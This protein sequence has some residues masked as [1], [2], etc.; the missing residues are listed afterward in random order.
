[1]LL[2]LSL[3]PPASNVGNCLETCD[4]EKEYGVD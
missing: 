4:A 2:Q 1:M 3:M